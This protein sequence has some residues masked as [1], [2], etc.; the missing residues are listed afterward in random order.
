MDAT[1]WHPLV[2]ELDPTFPVADIVRSDC[3]Y[4]RL[5][6]GPL[7]VGS[8]DSIRAGGPG[9]GAGQSFGD[10]GVAELEGV[11]VY[12]GQGQPLPSTALPRARLAVDPDGRIYLV[13]DLAP[14]RVYRFL[15]S[16][17]LDTSFGENG[18]AKLAD[19]SGFGFPAPE[20]DGRLVL[21]S[22]ADVTRLT[23]SGRFD[24]TFGAGGLLTLPDAG[25]PTRAGSGGAAF[26]SDGRLVV[27]YRNLL[28]RIR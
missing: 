9:L 13:A 11:Q 27:L 20:R 18:T 22:G 23:P 16:G 14:F 26:Q 25:T 24:S 12:E 17:S 21:V 8:D 4:T 28:L 3:S 7:A 2:G 5:S 6:T 15:P 1:A 10:A 19:A